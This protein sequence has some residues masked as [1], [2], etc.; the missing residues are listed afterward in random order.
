MYAL[1]NEQKTAVDAIAALQPR[2]RL[3][4][5]GRAGSGK[6]YAIAR[7]VSDKK[8]LILAP[9]H[10]AKAVLEQELGDSTHK[11]M[12]V[13]SAIGWY[14]S[15][16]NQLNDVEGYRSAKDALRP[17][18][19]LNDEGAGAFFGVDLVIVDESS[20]VGAFLFG[21]IEE[22]AEA[23]KLPVIYSGDVFQLPP[24]QDREVIA[25]QGF[26]T[27]T[28]NSSIRFPAESEIFTLGEDLRQRIEAQAWADAPFVRG[29]AEVQVITG[30]QWL[31]EL[32]RAYQRGESLLAVTSDNE[33]L[34]RLRGA[35]RGVEDDE[36][37]VGDVVLSKQTDDL[38]R[39]GEQLTISSMKK[40][41]RVLHDVPHAVSSLKTLSLS[42]YNLCFSENDKVAFILDNEYM[43]EK[44][45]RTTK[46][47]FA[48]D[49][50]T[51]KQAE[52]ILDW[53]AAS[54]RF[55]LAALA[56]VHKSQGRS[57]D[58]VYV[59]TNTVLKR[60][61]WVA[62]K[63]HLR[64]LYTA[65]TRARKRVVFYEMKGYCERSQTVVQFP[66]PHSTCE[67]PALKAA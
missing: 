5:S 54:N 23:F 14:K 32:T 35:I 7:S 36:L 11:I 48:K 21:A 37:A 49:K 66:Q 58:T 17:A 41:V 28:L 46:Y 27:Y 60:P 61:H 4:L 39:N 45:T 1:N 9:T 44:I 67:A 15:R 22:Y 20:M 31:A 64:L 26:D 30:N 63:N 25:H 24:V 53:L 10:P 59:D 56:T 29:G 8:A 13:H 47:L 50:L 43:A 6:T 19:G 57:V 42:G 62:P 34:K 2:G 33:S 16:D 55:E 40:S 65:I 38:F 12:T 3:V 52:R 18:E 51:L